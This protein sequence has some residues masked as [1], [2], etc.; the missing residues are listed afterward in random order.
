MIPTITTAILFI[1]YRSSEPS[2]L[3][4]LIFLLLRPNMT[5]RAFDRAR[6]N[7]S[8]YSFDIF[9]S[10]YVNAPNVTNSRTV[11]LL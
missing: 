6:V 11:L 8:I 7:D 3:P 4:S 5:N 1:Y 2:R 9:I 10:I